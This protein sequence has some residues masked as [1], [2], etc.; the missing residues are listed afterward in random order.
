MQGQKIKKVVSGHKLET[1]DPGLLV[2]QYGLG[3]SIKQLV[4]YYNKSIDNFLG[5]NKLK[6]SSC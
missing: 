4:G 3:N 2:K 5:G 6:L 1:I